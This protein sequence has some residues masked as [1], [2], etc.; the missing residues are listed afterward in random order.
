LCHCCSGPGRHHPQS[1]RGPHAAPAM[2]PR[3]AGLPAHEPACLPGRACHCVVGVGS[4]NRVG[5]GQP[6]QPGRSTLMLPTGP[7]VRSGQVPGPQSAC[8]DDAG[9]QSSP[10]SGMARPLRGPSP[11]NTATAACY[12]S[13]SRK[14]ARQATRPASRAC[15]PCVEGPSLA[16]PSIVLARLL[17]T[18]AIVERPAEGAGRHQLRERERQRERQQRTRNGNPSRKRM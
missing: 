7:Q 16:L 11:V 4:V 13:A 17:L 18:R 12:G 6:G 2:Q 1:A 14:T 9:R 10:N 3:L 5:S 8:H 15:S